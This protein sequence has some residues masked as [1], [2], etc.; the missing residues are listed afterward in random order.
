MTEFISGPGPLEAVVGQASRNSTLRCKTLALWYHC[1]KREQLFQVR[2][3]KFMS[4][5]VSR[6]RLGENAPFLLAYLTI[7]IAKI[8]SRKS[9]VASL[10]NLVNSI[11]WSLAKRLYKRVCPLVGWLVGWL[12]GTAKF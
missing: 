12:V 11:F 8:A 1:S 4:I 3:R 9:Q 5:S 10:H 2:L 6:S 7:Q